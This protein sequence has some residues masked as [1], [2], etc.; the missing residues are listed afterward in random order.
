MR[1][2]NLC[3]VENG[4]RTTPAG[5]QITQ[6]DIGTHSLRSG[7]CVCAC[8]RATTTPCKFVESIASDVSKQITVVRVSLA[9]V[10]RDERLEV[11]FGA[12]VESRR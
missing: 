10:Y 8:S 4:E 7:V 3:Y 2:K 9:L 1:T 11:N 6:N 5:H 12:D